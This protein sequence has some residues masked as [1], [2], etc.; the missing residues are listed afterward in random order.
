MQNTK[1]EWSHNT[2]NPWWGCT[3]VSPACDHC[4]AATFA[5]RHTKTED[6][7]WGKD[8]VRLISSDEYWEEPL[9]WDAKAAKTGLRERVFCGSMCDVMERR[10]W[11]HHVSAFTN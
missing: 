10:I 2:F 11:M 9:R 6:E 1:I 4:Y 5:G 7:L 3:K 8:A